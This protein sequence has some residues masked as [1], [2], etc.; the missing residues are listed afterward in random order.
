MPLSLMLWTLH[1][2]A[3]LLTPDLYTMPLWAPIVSFIIAI[4]LTEKK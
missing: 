3:P 1:F 4:L 2:A